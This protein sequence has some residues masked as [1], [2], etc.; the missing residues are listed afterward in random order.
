MSAVHRTANCH[1]CNGDMQYNKAHTA[2]HTA[3]LTL[4]Q[5][6]FTLVKLSALASEIPPALQMA[7]SSSP[8]MLGYPGFLC[9][10]CKYVG[11]ASDSQICS[12]RN[13][14]D[15][16]ASIVSVQYREA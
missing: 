7:F 5:R 1:A 12:S 11:N 3:V 16:K 10:P 6:R 13:R 15:L 14:C 4:L 2:W 8:S 9:M